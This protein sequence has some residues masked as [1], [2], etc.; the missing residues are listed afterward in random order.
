MNSVGSSSV[1]WNDLV[2]DQLAGIKDA[3]LNQEGICKLGFNDS[4]ASPSASTTIADRAAEDLFKK[5]RFSV[6][7][8]GMYQN[9]MRIFD[10]AGITNMI[11]IS[12][13]IVLHNFYN[14]SVA[15]MPLLLFPVAS[16]P[17]DATPNDTSGAMALLALMT[18]CVCTP[19]FDNCFSNIDS[20]PFNASD[21]PSIFKEDSWN[22]DKKRK[23]I[24]DSQQDI[25]MKRQQRCP[26]CKEFKKGHICVY[27]NNAQA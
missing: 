26:R 16:E 21:M 11:Y 1:E 15:P 22:L 6:P 9:Y 14:I 2:E 8:F 5:E 18:D 24:E 13:D 3:V 20:T 12:N 4:T 7:S 19:E 27:D 17:Y 10:S 25:V 23:L